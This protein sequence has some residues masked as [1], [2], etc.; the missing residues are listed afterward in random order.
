[1]I[2]PCRMEEIESLY[3]EETKKYLKMAKGNPSSHRIR[4]AY[5]VR[6]AHDEA[7]AAKAKKK[8]EKTL[9]DYPMLGEI[10][11]ERELMEEI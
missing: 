6:Y 2:G 9:K 10:Q 1:M 7:D 4:Y 5:A 8:F 3:T 11:L